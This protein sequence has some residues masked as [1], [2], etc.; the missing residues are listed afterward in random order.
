MAASAARSAFRL[1]N[2]WRPVEG[3]PT[4]AFDFTLVNLSDAAISGF[5][6]RLYLADAVAQTSAFENA[7]FVQRNANYH[8]FKPADAL[9]LQPGER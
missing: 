5:S 2:A 9:T 6:P 4:G 8:E 7:V 3:D 1:E